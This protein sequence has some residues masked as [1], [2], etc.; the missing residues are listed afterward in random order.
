LNAW[1]QNEAKPNHPIAIAMEHQ[2]LMFVVGSHARAANA[3]LPRHTQRG[4]DSLRHDDF[5][6]S[7][8]DP[9]LVGQESVDPPAGQ[10]GAAGKFGK[11]PVAAFAKRD[12]EKSN[13]KRGA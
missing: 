6:Y 13:N 8:G 1:Q 9:K 2:L 12:S 7:E 5:F 11:E 10:F 3:T 4:W